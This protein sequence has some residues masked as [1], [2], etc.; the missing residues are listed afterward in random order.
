[1]IPSKFYYF[2][3]LTFVF[4]LPVIGAGITMRSEIAWDNLAVFIL[5]IVFLGSIWDIWATRH[6]QKDRVWLW[7]FNFSD[8]LGIKIFGL[9]IEEYLF[10]VFASVYAVFIWEAIGLALHTK[11]PYYYALVIGMGAW[12]L[13]FAVFPYLFRKKGDRL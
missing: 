5:I 9:P 2:L 3:S 6:G 4:A 7:Q 10:Y 1:M 11:D 8:N 13:F 12:S